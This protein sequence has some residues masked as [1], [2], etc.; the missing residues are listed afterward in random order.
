MENVNFFE[1]LRAAL[2]KHAEFAILSDKS[3]ISVN[4]L[5][6]LQ[7]KPDEWFAVVP[8][9]KLRFLC[10]MLDIDFNKVH[11][12]PTFSEQFKL[13]WQG[14]Y[15]GSID[16]LK[17]TM[18]M[19]GEFFDFLKGGCSVLNLYPLEWTYDLAQATNFD[20]KKL[21]SILSLKD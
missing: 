17:S 13:D 4:S 1:A 3:L 2:G 5:H 8:F 7:H 9:Y 20:W 10:S 6:D 21:V 11:S 14:T 19:N 12:I 18:Y 16:S 15:L